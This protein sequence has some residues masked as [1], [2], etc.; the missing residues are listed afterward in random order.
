MNLRD[1]AL[2]C[3]RNACSDI[4]KG[5]DVAPARRSEIET[6]FM[7]A[8][9]REDYSTQQLQADCAEILPEHCAILIDQSDAER[10]NYPRVI[11]QLWQ[12]RAPV[13]PTTV[14]MSVPMSVPTTAPTAVPATKI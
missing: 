9:R 5:Y 6:L 8:M 2:H 1:E 10:E 14:P 11:L 13:V 7:L 3:L 12:Q 4:A